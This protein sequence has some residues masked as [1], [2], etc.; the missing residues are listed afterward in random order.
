MDISEFESK[1]T[2]AIIRLWQVCDLI[3]P[4]NDPQKDIDRKM[5]DRNGA[6]WVGR[7]DDK[8]VASIMIGYD[9]HR[10]TI[11]Y[12]AIDPAFKGQGFGRQL[13][14]EAEAF[15]ISIGCPKVSFCVRRDNEPVVQ[16]YD[17]LG[18]KPDDVF[19]FGKRLI[20]DD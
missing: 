15:L 5:T 1:D 11:N 17:A 8:V 7:V 2:V 6:F 10:G 14:K 16:F 20:P 4:W 3:R 18:Y 12:L 19:F 9:G 13:M